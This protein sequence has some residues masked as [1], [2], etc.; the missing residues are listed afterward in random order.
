MILFAGALPLL[1]CGPNVKNHPV[2]GTVKYE[3]GTDLKAGTVTFSPAE[4]NAYKPSAPISGQITDGKFSIKEVPEGK[5]KVLVTGSSAAGMQTTTPK[6]PG[7]TGAPATAPATESSPVAPKYNDP[8]KTPVP[9][10]E[11][12]DGMSS[13]DVKVSK[14]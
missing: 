2:S 14:P 13:V 7:V 3:D 11:V 12:K 6:D 9:V 1:G 8:D 4:G 5:W 10:V